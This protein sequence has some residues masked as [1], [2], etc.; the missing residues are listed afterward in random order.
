MITI[1]IAGP[2][3]GYKKYNKAAFKSVEKF[4]EATGE[5]H[6][7]NPARVKPIKGY[8][9]YRDYWHINKAMLRAAD[10]IYM[11]DGWEDSR[12]ACREHGYAIRHGIRVVY[13]HDPALVRETSR[14]IDEAFDGPDDE[15]EFAALS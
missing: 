11:L 7:L 8:K 13:E 10:V 6:V 14:M 2:M 5:Y 1:Y 12:G 4:L 15:M 3:T 9:S